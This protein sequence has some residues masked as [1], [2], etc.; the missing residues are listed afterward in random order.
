MKSLSNAKKETRKVR[1][2]EGQ[3]EH[4]SHSDINR[5][6]GRNGDSQQ[7]ESFR[8]DRTNSERQTSERTI[9]IYN[10]NGGGIIRQ[11]IEEFRA[12]VA[13]KKQ[14]IERLESTIEQFEAICKEIDNA[15]GTE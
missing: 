6:V 10:K 13:V 12:Q 8:V 3:S 4:F 14:E 1:G 5:Q 9:A 11:L 7:S 15:D 2:T